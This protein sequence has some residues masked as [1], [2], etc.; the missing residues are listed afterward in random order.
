MCTRERNAMSIV[1]YKLVVRKMIPW[2]YSSSRRKTVI[3][4]SS[5]YESYEQRRY[6]TGN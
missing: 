2:K 5:L 4:S 3:V 1:L 6:F